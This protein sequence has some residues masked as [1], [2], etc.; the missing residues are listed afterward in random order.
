MTEQLRLPGAVFMLTKELTPVNHTGVRQTYYDQAMNPSIVEPGE[1]IWQARRNQFVFARF[2]YPKDPWVAHRKMEAVRARKGNAVLRVWMTKREGSFTDMLLTAIVPKAFKEAFGDRIEITFF[3]NKSL[4]DALVGNPH[5]DKLESFY[6]TAASTSNL[7][8][9][10]L[11]LDNL[12][13]SLD[14]RVYLRKIGFSLID[15]IPHFMP[16][17]VQHPDI[18]PRPL[19]GV[20]WA[21]KAGDKTLR[22][23]ARLLRKAGFSVVRLTQP[24]DSAVA[25]LMK[26]CNVIVS[27]DSDVFHL[28]GIVGKRIVRVSKRSEEKE[29]PCEYEKATLLYK[30]RWRMGRKVRDAVIKHLTE[31]SRIL[32]VMLTYENLE[33]TKK[34][35]ASIRS[36]HDYDIFVVDNCS[37]DGT[38]KWLKQNKIEHVSRKLS[39]AAAQNV[40]IEKFN[41]GTWDYM[42]LVNNDI[43]LRKDYIDELVAAQKRSGAWGMMGSTVVAVP[44]WYVNEL[45]I[46]NR[47]DIAVEDIPA[48]S[49]SATL[50]TQECLE[51]VGLFDE[52]FTPRYMEDNDYTKRI[53]LAGGSFMCTTNA[54][55]YHGLGAVVRM[56][57]SERLNKT[58]DWDTNIQR[59]IDKWGEHPHMEKALGGEPC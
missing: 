56:I 36:W 53:K 14:P 45:E 51:T 17:A 48:G 27:N 58:K 10:I 20:E 43:V 18:L 38:R 23:S 22:R 34:A 42:L 59:Y 52:R 24:L 35:M 40:G 9:I 11:N 8:D 50:F 47:T 57:R 39:V 32:V 49:Y 19:I 28:A 31:P 15:N 3:T 30:K 29:N 33:M 54:Q 7:P 13:V 41:K 12:G 6:P 1:M 44:P 16:E 2:L 25:A 26:R 55:F 5:I 46:E 37:T 4:L 21:G